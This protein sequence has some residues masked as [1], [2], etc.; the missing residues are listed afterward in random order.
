MTF[1]SKNRMYI[2]IFFVLILSGTYIADASPVLPFGFLCA[3]FLYSMLEGKNIQY[4]EG[5]RIKHGF[6]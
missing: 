2:V 6:F 1:S 5:E 3:S 4:F